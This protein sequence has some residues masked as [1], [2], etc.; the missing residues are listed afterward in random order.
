MKA[1]VPEEGL[2]YSE[3]HEETAVIS[4]EGGDLGGSEIMT[5][6]GNTKQSKQWKEST[7]PNVL[8]SGDWGLLEKVEI[9]QLV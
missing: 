5:A 1:P 8:G 2:K 9:E 6:L 4:A 7:I 3:S